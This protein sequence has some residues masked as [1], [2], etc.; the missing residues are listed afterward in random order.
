MSFECIR[1][2]IENAICLD[3]AGEREGGLGELKIKEN[4]KNQEFQLTISINLL[5]WKGSECPFPVLQ[6]QL[7]TGSEVYRGS[8]SDHNLILGNLRDFPDI[9]TMK[10]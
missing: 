5:Q 10:V 6:T 2:L 7:Q 4:G 3:V 8:R 9:F 1:T